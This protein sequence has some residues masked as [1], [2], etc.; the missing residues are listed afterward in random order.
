MKFEETTTRLFSPKH[1]LFLAST[2]PRYEGDSQA[3][4]VLEQAIAWKAAR[5]RDELSILAP[6]EDGIEIDD[7]VQG[8]RVRRFRYVWP[9][10]W[11][12]LAYPAILPNI[13]RRPVVALLIPLFLVAEIWSTLRMVRKESVD[14][15]YAHWVFPQGFAAL[16]ANAVHGVPYV[17]QNHS[18]DLSVLTRIPLIG[19]SL[20]R[21]LIRRCVAFCCVNNNQCNSMLELF[22][23]QEKRDIRP[24]TLV[25]P[26]G[27]GSLP[28]AAERADDTDYYAFATMSRLSRKKG[29]GHFI[30]AVRRL[31]E[32]KYSERV[33]IVGDGELS[34]ELRAQAQGTGIE[35]L[36]FLT[37]EDK[38]K[39]MRRTRVFVVPSLDVSGDVE[40]LPVTVLE[41]L[42]L[43]RLL[44][45]TQATNIATLPEWEELKELVL[46]VDD[47]KDHQAFA[48]VLRHAM[49]L[50]PD[51][52][53]RMG[54]RSA[55]IA[56]RY[57]W[58]NLIHEYI[59]FFDQRLS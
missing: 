30:E 11:Q 8:I 6:H 15:I 59:D 27:V 20:A 12:K 3:P 50:P 17:L 23:D 53:R 7:R 41:S 2:F 40:G 25:L 49:S 54:Q 32:S 31:S 35:F 26:M 4:F 46:I 22:D 5:P 38:A 13:R 21:L 19:K 9:L 39:F 42:A 1:I 36:G 34:D 55:E 28:K 43:G 56:N 45:T 57:R 58:S 44:V 16:V 29:I 18:S 48:S 37:G 52:T 51:E 33:A 10:R 47:P 24:K 14:L